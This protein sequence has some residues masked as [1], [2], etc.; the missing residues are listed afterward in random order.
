VAALVSGVLIDAMLYIACCPL[1]SF[2]VRE[3]ATRVKAL[4]KIGEKSP[5]VAVELKK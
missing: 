1:A 3:L 4:K 2:Q 5:F